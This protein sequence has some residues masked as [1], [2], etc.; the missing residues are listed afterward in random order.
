MGVLIVSDNAQTTLNGSISSSPSV[1]SITLSNAAKFPIINNGGGGSDWSYVTFFDNLGNIEPVK[2]LRRDSG[3]NTLTIL[4]GTAAGIYGITDSDCKAWASGTTGVACRLIAQT[5][6]DLYDNNATAAAAASAAAAAASAAAASAASAVNAVAALLPVGTK[7]PF[8]QASAPTGWT[9]VVSDSADNRMLRVV[10]TAGGGVNG[11]HSPILNNVVP[12]H[13]HGITTGTE[14]SDHTHSG[15]TGYESA[16][17][18]HTFVGGGLVGGGW[19]LGYIVA[20]GSYAGAWNKTTTT[21][22]AN[23]YHSITT[24]GRSSV[25]T[26]SGTTDNGSSQVNWQPR[27]I[28]MIICSKN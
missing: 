7:M 22:S 3:S 26:H 17:H 2:V 5:V 4:R 11:T 20:C 15:N 12:A 10:K 13:T 9:Q 21:Q 8:A 23:H 25:H 24:G 16:S 28:D 19:G 14:S 1:N 6:K 18:S 27:Y